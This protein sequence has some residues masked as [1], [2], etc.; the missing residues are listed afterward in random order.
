MTDELRFTKYQGTRNDFVM[1]VDLD[2]VHPL[3]ADLAAALC[4][5]RTGVGADGVIRLVRAERPDAS[6][7]MDYRNADG[8]IAEMCG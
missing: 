6:F 4:H 7:V 1:V 2:D 3:E 8:S 5:R